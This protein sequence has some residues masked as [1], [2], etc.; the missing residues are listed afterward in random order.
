LLWS[1]YSLAVNNI[2]NLLVQ[3]G[4][5]AVP[6]Q[7]TSNTDALYAEITLQA[8]K[9]Y[10]FLVDTGA[11]LTTID[12]K[13]VKELRLKIE[14]NSLILG[15]G[16]NRRNR[17][18]AVAIPLLSLNNFSSKDEIAYQRDYSFIKV[19]KNPIS[20]FIGLT[21]LRKYH[22]IFDIV[23]QRLY[24]IYGS[25][26]SSLADILTKAGYKQISLQRAPSGHLLLSVQI[27]QAA[28]VPF[29]LDSGVPKTMISLTYANELGLK[30]TTHAIIGRGGGG[31]EMK[32]FKTKIN[33]L[34]IDSLA[35]MPPDV[36]ILDF[37]YIN[38]G[39]PVYGILGLD[40]MQAHQTILDTSNDKLYIG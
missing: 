27:N 5:T 3:Q 24:L 31:G 25:P 33:K 17:A 38:L 35:W 37:K 8:G 2:E 1:N 11:T 4:Y 19:D 36:A 29:M 7:R 40:W 21:F 20:G 10:Q 9:T 16:D 13:I 15:G 14:K 30:L 34:S 26:T 6:L 12:Q 28:P 22:A 39:T 18:Y 32:I 23:A